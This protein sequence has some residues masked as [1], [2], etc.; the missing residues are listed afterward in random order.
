L[1]AEMASNSDPERLTLVEPVNRQK[2]TEKYAKA[3]AMLTPAS[4]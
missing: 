3:K 1:D 2:L 4:G